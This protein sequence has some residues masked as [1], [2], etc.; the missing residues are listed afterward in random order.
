MNCYYFNIL[1]YKKQLFNLIKIVQISPFTYER[2]KK[3]GEVRG[4]KRTPDSGWWEP[5][6]ILALI[7]FGMAITSFWYEV[8]TAPIWSKDRADM[9]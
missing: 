4:E 8:R 5:Y 6:I 1:T 2:M 9:K 7:Y 3:N